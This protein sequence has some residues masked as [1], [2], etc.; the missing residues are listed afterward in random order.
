MVMP[1]DGP[2]FGMAPGGEVH[3]EP[4]PLEV[5]VGVEAELGGVGGA[6]S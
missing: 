5:G 3:V 6:R 1:A 2:S 4:S